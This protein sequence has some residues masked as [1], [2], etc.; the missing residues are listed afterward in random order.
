MAWIHVSVVVLC[1]LM[2]IIYLHLYLNQKQE[3]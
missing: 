1:N 3:D 2:T